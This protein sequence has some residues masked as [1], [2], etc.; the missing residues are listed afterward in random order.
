MLPYN[1]A[2]KYVKQYHA[3]T[4]AEFMRYAQKVEVFENDY[5]EICAPLPSCIPTD[6]ESYYKKTKEW[7]NWADFLSQI[8]VTYTKKYFTI[9]QAEKRH[10][11]SKHR[12]IMDIIQLQR[13]NQP[14]TKSMVKKAKRTFNN[15]KKP[16]PL[17]S[18]KVTK[19][20]REKPNNQLYDHA[21]ACRIVSKYGL[22][23]KSEYFHMLHVAE[24]YGYYQNAFGV[25]FRS[26][27]DRLPKDPETYYGG[28]FRWH[29]LLGHTD[30]IEERFGFLLRKRDKMRFLY[31]GV[32]KSCKLLPF[33]K[34]KRYVQQLH[35]HS[36]KE[37][38]EWVKYSKQ[39]GSY[40]NAFGERLPAKPSFIANL[41]NVCYQYTN[42]WRG[43]PD[44]L[45]IPKIAIWP[46]DLDPIISYTFPTA[47]LPYEQARDYLRKQNLKSLKLYYQYMRS[48]PKLPFY[49]AD[50][51]LCQPR[52]SKLHWLPKQYYSN[53]GTW[54]S[55]SDYLGCDFSEYTYED[56]HALALKYKIA[57]RMEWY[58][59]AVKHGLPRHVAS[60]C[61]NRGTWTTWL[62][63]LYDTSV[64]YAT[65]QD[66]MGLLSSYRFERVSD[67]ADWYAVH[68][69]ESLPPDLNYYSQF[70]Y[71]PTKLLG[72]S[73]E[74]KLLNIL[75]ARPVCYIAR[76]PNTSHN[77]IS[78]AIDYKGKANAIEVLKSKGQHLIAMFELTNESLFRKFI[79]QYCSK[80]EGESN[81]YQV[82]NL[83][84][85][86]FDLRSNLSEDTFT[87]TPLYNQTDVALYSLFRGVDMNT[88]NKQAHPAIP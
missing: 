70:G 63:F 44:F 74:D 34:A 31:N 2:K 11:N 32:Y 78:V 67:Y 17:I 30:N 36:A 21:T 38:N 47:F 80:Y 56:L 42:E 49:N 41:P 46:T 7:I 54:V 50:M 8:Q 19:L 51:E 24:V 59:F 14:V 16:P 22:L 40:I 4:K 65:P 6:P 27:T 62:D 66:A 88:S 84:Q 20:A 81:Q 79:Q 75:D 12:Q 1:L 55:W 58:Q 13:S 9:E 15:T 73:L 68:Q 87:D 53:M 28:Y 3:K 26:I 29:K 76:Y 33:E 23:D 35:L 64:K 69:P 45:G 85:L 61:R 82:Y 39:Y 52:L 57:N 86:L 10:K 25:V 72:I 37:Y 43:W 5:F 71:T 60:Y 83:A 77:I 18:K 48:N